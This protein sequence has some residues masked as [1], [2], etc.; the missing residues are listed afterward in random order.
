MLMGLALSSHM[1]SRQIS[2]NTD[3]LEKDAVRLVLLSES[4]DLAAMDLLNK[5]AE[6]S[7]ETVERLILDEKDLAPVLD[8]VEEF[9][10]QKMTEIRA[11]TNSADR[12]SREKIAKLAV[13]IAHAQ[14]D[15]LKAKSEL[16]MEHKKPSR[17]EQRTSDLLEKT[18]Q[19]VIRLNDKARG[20]LEQAGGVAVKGAQL[21]NENVAQSAKRARQHAHRYKQSKSNK[22]ARMSDDEQADSNNNSDDELMNDDQ[23]ADQLVA[24]DDFVIVSDAA[25]SDD[26]A[27][28][29]NTSGRSGNK[30]K[31]A[32]KK[33]RNK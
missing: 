14:S 23:V 27:I 28:Q 33:K 13:E 16:E 29:A 18:K 32:A 20:S 25:I 10:K 19:A 6:Q 26:V 12:V 22:A 1:Y 3:A 5:L 17:L 4:Y 30:K 7:E 9:L 31:A 24:S 21:L 15:F 11:L 2:V 8:K